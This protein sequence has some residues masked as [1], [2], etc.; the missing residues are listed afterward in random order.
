MALPKQI[1]GPI[2]NR[3]WHHLAG[4]GHTPKQVNGAVSDKQPSTRTAWSAP[5]SK[6]GQNLLSTGLSSPSTSPTQHPARQMRRVVT[7]SGGEGPGPPSQPC[8]PAHP[9]AQG[10]FSH[11]GPSRFGES[12]IR[13][14]YDQS[15]SIGP[16]RGQMRAAHARGVF[17]VFFFT[18]LAPPFALASAPSAQVK[19]LQLPSHLGRPC[20]LFTLLKL[21]LY[22]SMRGR[23][24]TRG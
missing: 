19:A 21:P 10:Q 14:R 17:F 23:T 22:P 5:E 7:W 16:I 4:H 3:A 11:I 18:K 6:G 8:P 20:C 1:K 13:C 24:E 2:G 15:A 12:V 9:P